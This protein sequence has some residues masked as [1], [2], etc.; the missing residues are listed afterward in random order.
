MSTSR[1]TIVIVGVMLCIRAAASFGDSADVRRTITQAIPY[2]EQNARWWIEEKKCV[3]CHRVAFTTWALSEADKQGFDVDR[4]QLEKWRG[5]SRDHLLSPPKEDAPPVGTTNLEGVSQLLLADQTATRS[6]LDQANRAKFVDFYSQKQ[7]DDGS[8]DAGGQLPD[9]KRPKA[10][11]QLVSTAWNALALGTVDEPAAAETRNKALAAIQKTT[12]GVSTEWHAVRLLVALQSK[13]DANAGRWVAKLRSTQRP[14]GG[15]G[16]ITADQ[17]DAMATGQALYALRAAGV[18][19]DDPAI[20][21]AVKFLVESQTPDGSWSVRGTKEK[22]KTRPAET[23]SYWGT[24]W[25]VLGLLSTI[26]V[27][28]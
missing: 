16:W 7:R 21:R 17:S 9:Q 13:S 18:A 1:M 19:P 8:W 22:S 3:A 11:T 5:W 20:E 10:E 27:P 2:V 6:V 23:A 12:D 15:W 25:A 26:D 28:Q 24:C 4:P 14:D